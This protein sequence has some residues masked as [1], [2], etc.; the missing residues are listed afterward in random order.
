[1]LVSLRVR[2]L[3]PQQ[4]PKLHTDMLYTGLLQTTVLAS[5]QYLCV[6]QYF[7]IFHCQAI[8]S[9]GTNPQACTDFY[10]ILMSCVSTLKPN[11]SLQIPWTKDY[12]QFRAD[13]VTNPF[14]LC[15]DSGNVPSLSTTVLCNHHSWPC[16]VSAKSVDTRAY[17][18][19]L[20]Y[21]QLRWSGMSW[22]TESKKQKVYVGTP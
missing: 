7:I 20:T 21:S 11:L 9:T 3:A 5:C 2:E 1:M 13:K 6:M 18:S 16:T 8:L 15:R 22:N 19:H 10:I 12:L 17:I 14:F 4:Q